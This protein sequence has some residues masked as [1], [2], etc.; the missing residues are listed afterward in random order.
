MNGLTKLPPNPVGCGTSDGAV[1]EN[2]EPVNWE[3]NIDEVSLENADDV[4]VA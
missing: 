3:E 2:D 4:A 1:V